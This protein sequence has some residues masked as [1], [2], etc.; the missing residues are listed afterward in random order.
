MS[1][2]A[3]IAEMKMDVVDGRETSVSEDGSSLG[4]NVSKGGPEM[5]G[6]L[7]DPAPTSSCMPE[8]AWGFIL[9][10]LVLYILM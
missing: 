8:D 10:V 3:R 5:V 6:Y 7:K 4:P 2:Q 9:G 1:A